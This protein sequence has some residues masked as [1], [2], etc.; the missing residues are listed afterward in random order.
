[1]TKLN[2]ELKIEVATIDLSAGRQDAK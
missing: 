2:A 1:M